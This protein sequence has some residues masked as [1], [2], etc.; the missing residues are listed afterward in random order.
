MK[1]EFKKKGPRSHTVRKNI[2]RM[3]A[4]LSHARVNTVPLFHQS[5]QE[6]KRIEFAH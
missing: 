3:R 5:L 2:D 4:L 1:V 6:Q